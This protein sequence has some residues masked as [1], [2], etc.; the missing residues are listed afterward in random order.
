MLKIFWTAREFLGYIPPWGIYHTY[1]SQRYYLFL[2]IFLTAFVCIPLWECFRERKVLLHNYSFFE[3]VSFKISDLWGELLQDSPSLSSVSCVLRGWNY[4]WSKIQ[5]HC[6]S[7]KI[8]VLLSLEYP[9]NWTQNLSHFGGYKT[10]HEIMIFLLPFLLY[11]LYP[12]W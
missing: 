12:Y 1:H 2:L 5:F 6:Q 7:F 11:S 3:W 9:S 4:L 10:W 8:L